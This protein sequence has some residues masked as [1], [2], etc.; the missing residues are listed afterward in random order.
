[1]AKSSLTLLH[2]SDLHLANLHGEIDASPAHA[3]L[4]RVVEEAQARGVDLLL[5]A[6][7]LFDSN[8]VGADCVEF[9]CDQL[10]RVRCPVV[11]I[12]GNHDCYTEHSVYHRFDASRAGAGV[13]LLTREEG[14]MVTLP[15]LQVRLWG[16]G[17]VDHH[18]GHQPLA[19]IPPREGDEWHLGMT[20]G[21]YVGR[22]PHSYSSLITAEEIAASA[23]DY[24]ALGH[25]HVYADVS[26]GATCAAYSGS[27]SCGPGVAGGTAALVTLDPGAG[28]RVAPLPLC[29]G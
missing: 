18:P 11:I 6:G 21:Y 29:E 22:G 8:R 26:Q 15:E 14:E 28:A 9:V 17:I 2:T 7:D 27:P 19:G 12:P 1:M 20:H 13:H 10:R 16:R 4:V 5:I 25:V 23:L 24:L 3:G